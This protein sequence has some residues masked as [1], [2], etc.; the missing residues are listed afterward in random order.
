MAG[1]R[2]WSEL[3]GKMTPEQR[4][5]SAQRYQEM[6]LGMLVAEM[7]K[8]SGMTQ[9]ELADRLGIGQSTISQIESSGDMH[10]TT[11]NKIVGEL[12]GEVVIHMPNGD[13]PLSAL[14]N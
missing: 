13:I 11:L 10:L 2:P 9:T 5:R 1:H 8:H 12:G 3:R 7:R 6:K 14:P 4:A